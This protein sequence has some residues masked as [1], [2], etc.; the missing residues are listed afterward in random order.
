MLENI[1][2]IPNLVATKPDNLPTKNYLDSFYNQIEAPNQENGELAQKQ[3]EENSFWSK[4][5]GGLLFWVVAVMVFSFT[6][7]LGY[8]SLIKKKQ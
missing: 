5:S 8:I 6:L 2:A 7:G 1:R 3:E 4:F